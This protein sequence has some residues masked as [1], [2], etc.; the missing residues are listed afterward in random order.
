LS[1]TLAKNADPDKTLFRGH[2]VLSGSTLFA[3]SDCPFP[4]IETNQLMLILLY[5]QKDSTDYWPR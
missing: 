2:K 3:M 4:Y 5:V 1:S